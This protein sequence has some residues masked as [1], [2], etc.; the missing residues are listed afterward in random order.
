MTH[1]T[2]S[3]VQLYCSYELLS[4]EHLEGARLNDVQHS[5]KI[6][7]LAEWLEMRKQNNSPARGLPLHGLRTGSSGAQG[8]PDRGAGFGSRRRVLR[9]LAAAA[10]QPDHNI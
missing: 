4:R 3:A 7:R 5:V 2:F 10:K 1:P 9:P 6:T 8:T